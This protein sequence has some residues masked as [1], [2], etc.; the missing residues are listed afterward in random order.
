ML[1]FVYTA[2]DSKT[3]EKVRAEVQADSEQAA[4][5]LIKNAGLSPL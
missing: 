5:K 4:A 3:G 1:T 2:R